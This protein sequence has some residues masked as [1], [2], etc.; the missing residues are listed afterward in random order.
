MTET[1]TYDNPGPGDSSSSSIKCYF[2]PALQLSFIVTSSGRVIPSYG[3]IDGLDDAG[4][5]LPLTPEQAA[6]QQ[7]FREQDG[8]D[9]YVSSV[10]RGPT[11]SPE[12]VEVLQRLLTLKEQT[13]KAMTDAAHLFAS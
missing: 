11:L 9:I 2:I 6:C 10:R 3:H 12:Q 8:Y 5:L 4:R 1:I 13:E 7:L